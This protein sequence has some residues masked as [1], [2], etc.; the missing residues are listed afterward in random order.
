MNR[1]FFIYLHTLQYPSLYTH[2]QEQVFHTP[3]PQ[4]PPPIYF[5]RQNSWNPEEKLGYLNSRT[6]VHTGYGEH[7]NESNLIPTSLFR[8]R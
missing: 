7:A 5:P 3:P 2:P 1:D 4:T 8:F 6:G